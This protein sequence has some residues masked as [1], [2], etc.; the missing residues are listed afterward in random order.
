MF[1][2]ITKR[3][4]LARHVRHR[5]IH[6]VEPEGFIKTLNCKLH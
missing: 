2:I 6:E 1:D 5:D 3:T 4:D